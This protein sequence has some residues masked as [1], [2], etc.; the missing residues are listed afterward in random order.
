MDLKVRQWRFIVRLC[1]PVLKWLVATVASLGLLCVAHAASLDRTPDA[2]NKPIRLVVPF[3]AGG[4]ADLVARAMAQALTD[5]L[6]QALVVDNRPGADGAIAAEAVAN[7]EPDGHT[8]FFATYGAMSAVPFL[9]KKI[10]YDPLKDF[11]P[12]SG[13]GKFSMF[14]FA[15]PDLPVQNVQQLIAYERAH[16]GQINYGTGNV[17]SIV[18]GSALNSDSAL[19]M[20]QVPYKGEV[21]AM[22]D[23]MAGRIQIMFATPT[24]AL[25]LVKEG[26]LHALASLSEKRSPLLPDVLTWRESGMHTSPIATWSGVFGPAKLPQPFV[27]RLSKAINEVLDMPS[28]QAQLTKQGFE[29]MGT[30]PEQLATYTHSQLHAWHAA[31]VTSGLTAD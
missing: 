11:T 24:N 30:T 2:L 29:P 7:A 9:H 10:R 4:S 5:K 26:R 21:P 25:P 22:S 18:L 23:F 27:Q 20:I 13:A 28:V 19:H 15:H 3:P 6:G 16:P 17:A 31:I 1:V 8:L 12:I 14:L